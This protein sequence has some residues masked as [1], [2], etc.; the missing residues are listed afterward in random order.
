[1]WEGWGTALKPAWEPIA[2]ARKPLDGTVA[3]NLA[4][5]GVGALNIDGCRVA[6][7]ETII[8]TRNVA[9]GSSGAGVFGSANTPGVYE[10]KSGGRWPANIVHDG[11][12]EVVGC[13]PYTKSGA[14]Q[15][16]HVRT[17]SKTKNAYGERAA[18]PEQTVASEGSAA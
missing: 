6:T 1:D 12:D 2:L 15:P 18:P 11:S 3:A 4:K 5:W 7:D 10:Q 8:A 16:H 9:L 13:F 17:T 14:I